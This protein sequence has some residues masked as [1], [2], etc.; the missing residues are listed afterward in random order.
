MEHSCFTISSFG[1]L[2]LQF[3]I[4]AIDYCYAVIPYDQKNYAAINPGE[5]TVVGPVQANTVPIL[6]NVAAAQ[7]TNDGLVT[8]TYDLSD[9]EY[10]EMDVWVEY[11]DGAVWNSA[12]TVTGAAGRVDISSGGI[13]LIATW[14]A[15]IDTAIHVTNSRIRVYARDA[16]QPVGT[17]YGESADFVLD[18][19]PPNAPIVDSVTT[20]TDLVN[21]MITGSK[22][23]SKSTA[24]LLNGVKIISL[25][26]TTNWLYNLILVEGNNGL[27]F[28]AQDAFGNISEE[29]S[30]RAFND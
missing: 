17:N 2:I 1:H 28:S 7:G 8:I 29:T 18:T 5:F 16:V 22:D 11:W 6:S 12:G 27:A 20:P 19:L 15:R 10:T 3:S 25:N 26:T 4:P 9:V 14:D 13:G 23:G 24:L 21:Q 30:I